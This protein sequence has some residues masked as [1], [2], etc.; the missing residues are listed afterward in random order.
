MSDIAAF[1]SLY[2][3]LVVTKTGAA[4][5]A[6]IRAFSAVPRELFLGPGPW[7]VAIPNGYLSTGTS[8][9][10]ILYQDIPI[11]L[12]EDRRINNGQPALHAKALSSVRVESGEAVVHVG[13]GSGYY[14]AILADLVEPS[15]T[16]HAYEIEA[17]L[18]ARAKQNLA[19]WPNVTVHSVSG[20]EKQ[21]LPMADVIYVNAGATEPLAAWLDILRPKGR[22]LFPLTGNDGDGAM[23]LVTRLEGERFA[24]NFVCRARFIPCLGA[25]DEAGAASVA[26]A[27]AK[28][29][30][31]EVR[32][33]RRDGGVDAADWCRGA[34]WRLSTEPVT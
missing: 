6:L 19:A 27:F 20:A 25:R 28:R 11:G 24:A 1:R 16:V 21:N 13:S 18:A 22:L 33:L 10:R 14:S 8:D 23:L 3:Q 9:P 30:L 4:T 26:A 31:D 29:S 32:S 17:D 7:R 34:D 2:A 12:A 5:D 15:G